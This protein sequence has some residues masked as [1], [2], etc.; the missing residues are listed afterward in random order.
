MRKR[1]VSKAA[2]ET[3]EDGTSCGYL[4]FILKNLKIIWYLVAYGMN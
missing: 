2:M 1:H 3:E 4:A